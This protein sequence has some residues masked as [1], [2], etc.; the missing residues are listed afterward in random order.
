MCVWSLQTSR[1]S[2]K[3][4]K[5]IKQITEESSS[6]VRYDQLTRERMIVRGVYRP[7]DVGLSRSLS[8]ETLTECGNVEE[9]EGGE[10]PVVRSEGEEVESEEEGDVVLVMR[11]EEE[12]CVAQN[13]ENGE[14]DSE[15]K[16]SLI[17]NPNV[18]PS[19]SPSPTP[20]SPDSLAGIH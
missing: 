5:S 10:V 3:S 7:V 17:P 9:G 12:G 19:P 18:T 6:S 8:E 15:Q 16:P 11:S 4:R 2:R 20:L 1:K 13:G 14:Q